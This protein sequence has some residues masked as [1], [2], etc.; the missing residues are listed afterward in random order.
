MNI[1]I[2]AIEKV[3]KQSKKGTSYVE[4]NVT[5]RNLDTGRVD[6]KKVMSFASKEVYN[7][8]AEAQPNDVFEVKS[9]KQGNYWEWVSIARSSAPVDA[10]SPSAGRSAAPRSNFETPE[11]R[12]KRQVLIVRQSSLSSAVAAMVPGAKSPLKAAEV[13]AMA[14]EFESYV[15][16]EEVV[17]PVEE[18]KEP[19]IASMSEDI[20]Y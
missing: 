7:M 1:R 19:D 16:G 2:V 12:A 3:T 17:S 8:L 4:L 20:P 6:A 10:P 5:F 13:I 11:E 15:F 14:K 9:E 18:L